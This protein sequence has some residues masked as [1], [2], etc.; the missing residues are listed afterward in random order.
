MQNWV[1]ARF[2]D[3]VREKFLQQC[4]EEA[5]TPYQLIRPEHEPVSRVYF[6]IDCVI[7]VVSLMED[8]NMAESYTVGSDGMLGLET[9]W[10]DGH[11]IFRVMCQIPGRTYSLEVERFLQLVRGDERIAQV[12][13]RYAYCLFALTGRAAA[14]NLLHQL[15]ARCARWLLIS[16]DRVQRET[17][18]ITQEILATMLGVHRPAV[19]LAAGALQK[20]GFITY[21]RGRITIVDRAGLESA[22]CECYAL[23]AEEYCRVLGGPPP[24]R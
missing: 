5:L 2:P 12:L 9:F 20:A 16:H 3:D 10:S 1:L 13:N 19:S 7:S 21:T 18:E 15:I 14:C 24:R 6:P 17:F 8:G 22:S 11:P 23:I 4:T